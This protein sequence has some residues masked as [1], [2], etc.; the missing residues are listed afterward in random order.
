VQN[1]QQRTRERQKIGGEGRRGK[2]SAGGVFRFRLLRS[3]LLFCP[4]PLFPF[5]CSSPWGRRDAYA[6]PPRRIVC[7]C[8]YVR[9]NSASR[10]E[11]SKGSCDAAPAF[12]ACNSTLVDRGDPLGSAVRSGG[13]TPSRSTSSYG[14]KGGGKKE[15]EEKQKEKEGIHLGTSPSA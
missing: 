1:K 6:K 5:F 12:L 11:S 8:M 14:E 10:R 13:W 3:I 4:F 9:S 2:F 15:R 7:L